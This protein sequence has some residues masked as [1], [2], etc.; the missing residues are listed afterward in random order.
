MKCS[1]GVRME[2]AG[3][4]Y[5]EC[6]TG[7]CS[8]RYKIEVEIKEEVDWRYQH[9]V[10]VENAEKLLQS[11]RERQDERGIRTLEN[12]LKEL[13]FNLK[14]TLQAP[15]SEDRYLREPF[16]VQSY[17]TCNWR[18]V[19]RTMERDNLEVSLEVVPITDKRAVCEVYIKE[20]ADETFILHPEVDSFYL[21][22]REPQEGQRYKC[23]LFGFGGASPVY[24]CEY[25][26][27]IFCPVV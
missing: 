13:K 2:D 18:I 14:R 5:M 6:S 22:G 7:D 21:K 9:A 17:P 11:F 16:E 19:K 12:Y 23:V 3:N 1:C 4:G 24:F 27:G 10:C 20:E 15:P 25:R 26:D 8:A